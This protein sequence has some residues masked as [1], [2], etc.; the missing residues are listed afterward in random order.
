M[1]FAGTFCVYG[2]SFP[3]PK[4][5]WYPS[6]EENL[7]YDFHSAEVLIYFKILEKS[8]FSL[9]KFIIHLII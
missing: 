3:S 7:L 6:T 2:L 9:V 1:W 5:C 8:N 4:S